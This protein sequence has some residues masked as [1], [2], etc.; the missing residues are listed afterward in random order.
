MLVSENNFLK[1]KASGEISFTLI[2]FI[3]VQIKEPASRSTTT[4]HLPFLQNSLNFTIT[5]YFKQEVNGNLSICVDE[6]SPCDLSI[7]GDI[8]VLYRSTLWTS[9]KLFLLPKSDNSTPSVTRDKEICQSYTIMR[10][11]HHYLLRWSTQ[12]NLLNEVYLLSKFDV[13]SFS[14]TGDI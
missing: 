14:M 10:S 13:S 5:K 3:L 11:W 6:H 9:I 1:K 2:S 12:W 8:K 7:T 4:E